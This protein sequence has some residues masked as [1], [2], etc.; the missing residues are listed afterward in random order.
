MISGLRK[1]L[2]GAGP[3]EHL[4]DDVKAALAAW[5][6]SDAGALE[7][8]HFMTR[9]VVVDIATDGQ[10]PDSDRITGIAATL[11]HQGVVSPEQSIFVDL[12]GST[13]D[14]ATVDRQLAAFL[15]FVGKS[16]LVSYHVAYVSGFLQQLL[17][18]RLGIG[19]APRWVDLT[20]LLPAMFGETSHKPMPLDD[21]LVAFGLDVGEGRRSPTAN[22][23]ALARLLQMTIVRAHAKGV[24]TVDQ[25][26]DESKASSHL[27]RTH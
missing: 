20:W 18:K 24:D 1:F 9:Y 12:A 17:K 22:S 11:V 19:F 10:N 7:S 4:P 14:D 25:L 27:R 23:L 21:W 15:R 2:F 6:E 13:V 3:G 8:S 26:I 16:P 5:Q